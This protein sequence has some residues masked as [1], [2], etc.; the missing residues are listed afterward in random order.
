MIT[1]SFVSPSTYAGIFFC[2]N[3]AMV[4]LSTFL[5]TMVVNL[6]YRGADGR[7]PPLWVRR[8]VIDHLGNILHLRQTIPLADRNSNR[9]LDSAMSTNTQSDWNRLEQSGAIET[10]N[11][12]LNSNPDEQNLTYRNKSVR[13]ISESPDLKHIVQTQLENQTAELKHELRA[14]DHRRSKIDHN[15]LAA[16]EWR[17]LALIVDR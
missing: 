11:M 6:F 4:T 10:G 8:Y 3:M 5:A 9:D 16:M 13:P 2:L 7:P 1:R 14:L 12:N 15:E 17:T